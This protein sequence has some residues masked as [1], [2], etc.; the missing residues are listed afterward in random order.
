M[1][2]EEFCVYW[3]NNIRG[4]GNTKISE[5]MAIFGS[6]CGVYNAGEQELKDAML[7]SNVRFSHGDFDNL[8]ACRNAEWVRREYESL[9]A[10]QI[11][12]TYPGRADYPVRLGMIYDAPHILYYKGHLPDAAPSVA[13]IGARACSAY[14]RQIA[15]MFGRELAR[16][17]VQIVSGLATGIDT[18]GQRAS[19]EAG[20]RT[21]AVLGSGVDVCYPRSNIGLYADT[22]I[23]GGILSEYPPGTKPSAGNFPVRNRIISALAD[24]VVVVE[25]RRR[26]GTLI[27][28][29]AAL[30]Q[31]KDIMAVPGRVG[32]VLSEGCNYLLK[33]GAHVVTQTRDILEILGIN[34]INKKEKNNIVLASEEEKVYGSICL[35]PK[36]ID[37]IIEE[38]HLTPLKVCEILLNLELKDMIEQVSHNYYVRK[39]CDNGD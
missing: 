12:F 13:I 22:M 5:L 2:D 17:G 18:F 39:M 21:F 14:G 9:V 10:K 38:T 28:V 24:V 1:V 27:T 32:D 26:S 36:S 11:A 20:G 3:L 25:A 16:A 35:I 23:H 37:I 4:I 30:E 6:A 33:Q 8:I 29:D 34:I 19:A 31:N 7:G 15:E